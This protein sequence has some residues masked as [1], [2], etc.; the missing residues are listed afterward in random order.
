MYVLSFEFILSLLLVKF[1]CVCNKDDDVDIDEYIDE[2][3]YDYDDD[4]DD[5]CDNE[6]NDAY[7]EKRTHHPP[8]HLVDC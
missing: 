5:G 6:E 4:Y 7:D 2:Y 3:D 1:V 8:I